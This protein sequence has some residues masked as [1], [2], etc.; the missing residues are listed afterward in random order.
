MPHARG[1]DTSRVYPRV[2]MITVEGERIDPSFDP[3]PGC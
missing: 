2:P 1:V 3:R